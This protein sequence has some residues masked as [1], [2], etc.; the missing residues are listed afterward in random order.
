MAKKTRL[1]SKE[2]LLTSLKGFAVGIVAVISSLPLWIL[3]TYLYTKDVN[4][5]ATFF[6]I[7][8]LVVLF[9]FFGYWSSRWWNWK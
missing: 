6:G 1:F 7:F 5:V 2:S 3:T 9:L 8:S 4:G